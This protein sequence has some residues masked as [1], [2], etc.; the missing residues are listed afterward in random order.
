MD[1]RDDRSLGRLFSDLSRQLSTLVRQEIELARTEI[2]ASATE[3]ARD[4]SL[5]GAGGVLLHTAILGAF[6]TVVLIL[7]Q[8]G[9]DPWLAALVVTAVVAVI[10]LALT[11]RGRDQLRHR[12]LVPKRTVETLRDDAEWAKERI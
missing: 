9:L 10:G 8:L 3:T 11:M 5:I 1:D 6:A 12:S 2:T 4:A 7:A